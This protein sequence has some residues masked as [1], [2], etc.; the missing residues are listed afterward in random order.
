MNKVQKLYLVCKE[1]GIPQMAEY[2]GYLLTK[3]SGWLEKLTPVGGYPLDFD[4]QELSPDI[5]T[6][7]P[8]QKITYE[9][10]EQHQILQKAEEIL[11]GFYYP[12]GGNQKPLSFFQMQKPLTHWTHYADVVDSVD[13]K[14]IWEPA[15][16]SFAFD[17][18]RAYLIQPDERYVKH[19]W[20]KF[21]E[22]EQNN[23]VNSGPNWV[24]AQEAAMRIL[25]WT[26]VYPVFKDS[27]ETTLENKQRLLVSIWQHAA[28]IPP[29][30]AY[31]RSQNNNHLLSEALGL[32]IA[33]TI[34]SNRSPRA[35]Q[36]LKLGLQEF[37]QGLIKQIEPDG[38]YSQHS[39]NYHRLML[40]LSLVF[41]AYAK[42][43]NEPISEIVKTRLAAA[44]RWM[45][46]QLDPTSGRLP[47]L[48]HNDGTL[49]LPMGCAE[50]RDYR[51]T[52]QA[53]SLAFLGEPC[54]PSGKWDELCAWLGLDYEQNQNNNTKSE[55]PTI[56]K[57][58][59]GNKW[60]SLRGVHFHGRPAHADQ[61]HLEIWW[62][63]M[64]IAQD[65]G[66]Y[67]YND[68][69]P[70]QNPFGSTLNHN[71]LSV[72]EKDQMQKAGKF[73]WLDQAQAEWLPTGKP[74]ILSARHDGYRRIG[75]SH[76]RMVEF[77]SANH[78]QV[79]DTL[80]LS[81][82]LQHHK[83]TIHWLLPDWHWKQREHALVI[84]TENRQIEIK[85]SAVQMIR[86]TPQL[87][88]DLSIIRGG[89]NLQGLRSNSLLGWTSETYGVKKPALSYSITYTTNT[90]LLI[91]TD[92]IFTDDLAG[93]KV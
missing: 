70:W 19:F 72:D 44:T 29:T 59:I 37:S 16:F 56:H 45:N 55:S 34:F 89:K 27:P 67:T 49:L 46:A 14:W 30:L 35:R 12:F 93:R 74:N 43:L 77:Q 13:I 22:F 65:A 2:A 84:D 3:K 63:G 60:A 50:F 51:P 53:A 79:T 69:T 18:A 92:W 17:L 47:N 42:H 26:M 48:G 88:D 24:S 82:G 7:I 9:K 33:G 25:T 11:N 71:T 66:T 87:P 32:I 28:R 85:T 76:Q 5:P 41:Y 36:W 57:I 8:S 1:I 15:R 38:T 4:L 6:A 68:P 75:V 52:A 90:D 64:N 10:T 78:M 86:N 61:L 83:I 31:A 81:G 39:A 40:Q 73:L 20:E 23:P 80:R 21:Y 62:D 58:S 54:L 91:L